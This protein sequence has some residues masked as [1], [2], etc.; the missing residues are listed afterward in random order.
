MKL[1][2]ETDASLEES[3]IIIRCREIT[4]DIEKIQQAIMNIAK[5]TDIVFY[6]ANK[7][8]YLNINSVLFFESS[9]KQIYA[10]TADDFFTA[11]KKLYEL[12]EILPMQFIRVSKSTIL[13]VNHIYSIEKNITS[14]SPVQFYGTHKQVYVS[15]NY[16]KELKKRIEERRKG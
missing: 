9:E 13:N 10:H 15:R 6:K 16:Y 2:T 7:E 11:G 1:R 8:Y 5:N 14:A 4:P 12:E 3:E